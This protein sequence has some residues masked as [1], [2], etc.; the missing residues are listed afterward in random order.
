MRVALI[1]DIHANL[2]ALDAALND[3]NRRGVDRVVCLGDVADLGPQP[4]ETLDRLRGLGIP[5][6]QGNHDPFT[7][8]FPGLESL[9]EWC[10]QRLGED[11]VEYLRQLPQSLQ[12][13]LAP[14]THLL[15]LHGSP[16]SY[17]FQLTAGTPESDLDAWGLSDQVAVVAC[18]HTHVQVVRRVRGRTFVNVGS[19][20]QPFSALFDGVNP[21][22]CFKK[23]EY[24]IVEWRLGGLCIELCSVPFDFDAY[25]A[26]VRAA[27]F[28]QP[29]L[30]L[31]HWE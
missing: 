20:G 10:R 19:V 23:A 31:R 26:S 4:R 6:V 7:E 2:V 22:V 11:G 25:A 12:V 29:D 5:I 24:A 1:S 28:P 30:W 27:R 18:G 14:G 8:L 13:E 17:D 21:P 15:C 9:V 3:M 16:T